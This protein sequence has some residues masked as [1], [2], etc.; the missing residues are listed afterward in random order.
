M[1]RLGMSRETENSGFICVHC[2][3]TV[4]ALTNGSYR[5]HCPFCLYSLHVDKII[6]DRTNDCFGKMKPQG[7]ISNTKKGYQ[8][9]HVCQNCGVERVNKIAENTDMPDDFDE[10]LKLI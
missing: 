5:N 2:N 8:I 9:V 1:R 10:I 3:K 7:L 4:D 6:G